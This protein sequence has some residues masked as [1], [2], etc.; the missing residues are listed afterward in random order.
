MCDVLRILLGFQAGRRLH[1]V[2]D[3]IAPVMQACTGL[4]EQYGGHSS[5]MLSSAVMIDAP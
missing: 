3:L 1:V 4:A 2:E 5:V